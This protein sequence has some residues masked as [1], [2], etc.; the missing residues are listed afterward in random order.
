MEKGPSRFH[1]QQRGSR[2]SGG[3]GGGR[4]SGG[5][6]RPLRATLLRGN[7]GISIE[8]GKFVAL[9]SIS[10]WLDAINDSL[11]CLFS[12]TLAIAGQLVFL[13]KCTP[14]GGTSVRFYRLRSKTGGGMDEGW[15]R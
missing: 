10:G 9:I 5:A 4:D 1:R 3:G 11:L 13:A 14:L 12:Q 2:H 6:R 15:W 8:F 7:K